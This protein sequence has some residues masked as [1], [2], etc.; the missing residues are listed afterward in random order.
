MNP[1]IPPLIVINSQYFLIFCVGELNR[2]EAFFGRG[3]QI[4]VPSLFNAIAST[5]KRKIRRLSHML[6]E[7]N[8]LTGLTAVPV[9]G[10]ISDGDSDVENMDVHEK[11]QNQINITDPA[12]AAA[13]GGGHHA[14]RLVVF[15]QGR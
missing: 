12:G 8:V 1:F 2:A 14:C 7:R 9:P 3:L 10:F 11:I 6:S 13:G 4:C 5:S 15:V